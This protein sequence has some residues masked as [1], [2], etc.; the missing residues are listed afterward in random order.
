MISWRL[1]HRL[2]G[3]H[4]VHCKNTCDDIV[5]RVHRT[6]T[7]ERYVVYYG[8]NV[9][10]IDRPECWWVVSDLT[11]D[12]PEIE[13]TVTAVDRPAEPAPAPAPLMIEHRRTG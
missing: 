3:W 12:R 6:P 9:I 4:Y 8:Q 1:K 13:V 10:W 7:G 2:F 11:G 5:R